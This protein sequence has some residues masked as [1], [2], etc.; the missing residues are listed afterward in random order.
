MENLDID[1][2]FYFKIYNDENLTPTVIDIRNL[3]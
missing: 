3:K 2:S 1:N